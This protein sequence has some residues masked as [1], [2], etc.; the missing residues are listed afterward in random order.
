METQKTGTEIH[1]IDRVPLIHLDPQTGLLHVA[2]VAKYG[3][4]G[5]GEW[6]MRH[7]F[8]LTP[9][10]GKQLLAALPQLETLLEKQAEGPTRP[11]A[12]Q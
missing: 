4:Q 6:E 10:I 5:L 12:L 3:R 2:V 9:A 8:V 11:N 1:I 7:E